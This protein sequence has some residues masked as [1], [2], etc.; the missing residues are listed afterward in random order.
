MIIEAY[1]LLK[2]IED[3][4]ASNN[5]SIHTEGDN[6][7]IRVGFKTKNGYQYICGVLSQN[8]SERI[9]IIRFLNEVNGFIRDSKSKGLIK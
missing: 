5:V 2:T 6:I 1:K 3:N 4:T 7:N 8:N 9:Q